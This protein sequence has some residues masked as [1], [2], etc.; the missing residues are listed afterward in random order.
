MSKY[1]FCVACMEDASCSAFFLFPPEAQS[2]VPHVFSHNPCPTL[3]ADWV[4]DQTRTTIDPA[5]LLF[6]D[7]LSFISDP[8]LATDNLILPT[9]AEDII[10][11]SLFA[12]DV[13]QSSPG[14]ASGSEHDW[15]SSSSSSWFTQAPHNHNHPQL[16][17]SLPCQSRDAVSYSQHTQSSTTTPV[18]SS[19]QP[20]V[21]ANVSTKPYT[22]PMPA[23]G[24][25]FDRK[26]DF[27]YAACLQIRT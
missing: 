10:P 17:M 18:A 2:T 23:C 22:C 13:Y 24:K 5:L 21:T 27:E 7:P 14:L 8:G 20:L 9:T 25:H 16:P 3:T 15:I 1:C 26:C 6:T 11:S 12:A 4:E 19:P